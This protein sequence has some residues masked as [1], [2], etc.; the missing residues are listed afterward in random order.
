MKLTR[1]AGE[2]ILPLL[3]RAEGKVTVYSPFISPEYARLLLE[4]GEDGV[5][6]DLFT[7]NAD[8]NYHQESL[9]ILRNGP[10][11]PKTLRNAGLLLILLGVAGAWVAYSLQLLAL[12]LPLLLLVGGISGG[13]YLLKKHSERT[14]EWSEFHG[15]INIDV[16]QGLHAKVYSRDGGE[17]VV[18]GS[19]NFTNSGMQE[20]LEVV[21]VCRNKSPLQEGSKR[22]LEESFE[23]IVRK[24]ESK[25][26]GEA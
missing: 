24:Q 14:S 21:G 16:V 22:R 23:N 8:T 6:V 25:A 17:E 15:D 20:N 9:R 7:A 11:L 3:D 4:K 18:F 13:G 10:E 12:P 2:D 26:G 5:D 19:P 1:K